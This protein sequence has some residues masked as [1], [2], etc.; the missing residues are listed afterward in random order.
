MFTIRSRWGHTPL[1][2]AERFGHNEV[3]E[4]LHSWISRDTE[5][6]LT[7][8]TGK[9]LLLQL[10]L[11]NA[12]QLMEDSGASTNISSPAAAEDKNKN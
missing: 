11:R 1:S 7:E 8:K 5:K 4:F 6:T 9:A 12:E 2:E 3:A 10:Q